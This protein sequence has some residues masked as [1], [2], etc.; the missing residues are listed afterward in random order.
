MK[1]PKSGG[2][3]V[4]VATPE[5]VCGGGDAARPVLQVLGVEDD[6]KRLTSRN[7]NANGRSA[8]SRSRE[9]RS[10]RIAT[11]DYFAARIFAAVSRT[12]G[13]GSEAAMVAASCAASALS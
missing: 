12:R 1:T 2:V 8:P 7:A 13:S 3:V 4:E 11:R 10:T 9:G 6:E 5:S